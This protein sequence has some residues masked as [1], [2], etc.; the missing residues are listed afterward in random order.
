MSLNSLEKTCS[1]KSA[2]SLRLFNIRE[3]K[4]LT[5]GKSRSTI[6]RWISSGDFPAPIKVCGS[7]MW[8]E[9]IIEDWR[10]KVISQGWF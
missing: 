7:S 4:A 9:E 3:V 10:N 1:C 5:G 6:Y 8:P 2:K